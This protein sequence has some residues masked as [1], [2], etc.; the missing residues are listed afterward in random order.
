MLERPMEKIIM[1]SAIDWNVGSIATVMGCLIPIVAIISAALYK[2]IK[3]T[4]ENDLKRSMVERDWSANEVE[5][6]LAAKS[7][8]VK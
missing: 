1:L 4:S 3:T 5:Q 2:A 8:R 6:V 7:T